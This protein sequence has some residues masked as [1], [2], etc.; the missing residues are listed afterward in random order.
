MSEKQESPE[1]V[2]RQIRPGVLTYGQKPYAF[3]RSLFHENIVL[4]LP[5]EGAPGEDMSGNKPVLAFADGE[6]NYVTTSDPKLMAGMA[7][8]LTEAN[9]DHAVDAAERAKI[10][11][12]LRDA[13]DD[14]KLNGSVPNVLVNP[15]KGASR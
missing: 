5:A 14:G 9:G 15:P 3:D 2:I 7:K 11:A 6:G 8:I 1:A 10:N 13:L 12:I 4:G